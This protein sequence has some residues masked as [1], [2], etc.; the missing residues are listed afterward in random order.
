MIALS[1]NRLD[2][3]PRFGLTLG[4]A[5]RDVGAG[6]TLRAGSGLGS[7]FGPPLIRPSA[8]GSQYFTPNQSLYWY[9]FADVMWSTLFFSTATPITT[10][11]AFRK[12]VGWARFR[13]ARSWDGA[14]GASRSR[15]PGAP[16]EFETQK[17]PD[18]FG[19]IAISYRF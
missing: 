1:D 13:P 18:E 12:T 2:V 5:R 11:R 15:K 14:I 6:F 19:A 8:A 17:N 7:D 10:A 16:R 3:V 4:S 9:L